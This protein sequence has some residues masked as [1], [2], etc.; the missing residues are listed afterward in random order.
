MLFRSGDGIQI[1]ALGESFQAL[2]K[3]AARY[4]GAIIEYHDDTREGGA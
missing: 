3:F 2:A 4:K 1:K